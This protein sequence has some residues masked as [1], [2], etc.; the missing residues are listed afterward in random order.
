VER[1]LDAC[2]LGL[3]Q[4][5]TEFLPISS[6]GHLAIFQ[7]LLGWVDPKQNLAFSVALHVG[8][9]GAVVVFVW[10][11][12]WAMVTTAPRLL[13]VLVVA[14]LPLVAVGPW[15]KDVVEHL[16]TN[17]YAVGGFLCFTAGLLALARR[18]PDGE[19]VAE[20]LPLPRA[21]VIGIAQVLAVLPGVSRSGSTLVAGLGTGLE[22]EQAVRFAFLMAAPAIGGAAVLMLLEG[23]FDTGAPPFALTAGTLVSFAAS[24][25]AMKVMVGVVRRRRLGWFALYCVGAGLLAITLATR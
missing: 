13:L 20:K 15:A 17:L 6:S 9:L 5:L 8:S 22:R 11:E 16:Q 23:G 10:K 12:I 4:G 3:V 19:R 18:L 2:V 24:L 21:L 25:F 7:K 14:T 1:F